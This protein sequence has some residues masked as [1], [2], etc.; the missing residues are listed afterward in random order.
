MRLTR[1]APLALAALASV[2]TPTARAHAQAPFRTEVLRAGEA[3]FRLDAQS[4][5]APRA[6]GG[7]VWSMP[8]LSVGLGHGLEVGAGLSVIAP[9][10]LAS[11]NRDVTLAAKWAPLAGTR[12]PVQLAVG[13]FAFLPSESQADGV[14]VP[15]MSFH[16]LAASSPIVPAWGDAG[17]QLS[18]AGLLVDGPRAGPF[19]DRR[20][21]MVGLDQALP[22]SLARPIGAEVLVLSTGWVSGQTAFSYASAS[23]VAMFRGVDVSVGYTRGNLAT[24]NHGPSIG[25]GFRF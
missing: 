20:A 4:Y 18:V 10:P 19:T 16:Y 23:L 6:E 8:S 5:A 25:L 22:L 14:A 12:S 9:R 3:Q 17:P 1:L 24:M 21:M 2:V 11:A 7:W 15:R 13:T